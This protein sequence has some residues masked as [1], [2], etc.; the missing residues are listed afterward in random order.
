MRQRSALTWSRM[1][2]AAC[3]A[4]VS[5]SKM[6]LELGHEVTQLIVRQLRDVAAQQS[7][8]LPHLRETGSI[9]RLPLAVGNVV[10]KPPALRPGADIDEVRRGPQPLR[11][12]RRLAESLRFRQAG[13]RDV[14]HCDIAGFRHQLADQ[15]AADSAAAAGDYRRPPREFR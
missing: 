3:A 6:P 7:K 8:A 9:D 15:L 10:R 14:A 5:A 11:R 2:V 12:S 4:L 13:R 1:I